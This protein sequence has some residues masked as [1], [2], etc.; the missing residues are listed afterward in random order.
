MAPP[1]PIAIAPV[2]PAAAVP[3]RSVREPVSE[4]VSD[5]SAVL[6]TR[7]LVFDDSFGRT[8]KRLW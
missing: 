1:V 7:L 2:L 3:V 6:T 5:E 4:S 8:V